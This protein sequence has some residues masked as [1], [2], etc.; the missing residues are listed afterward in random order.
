MELITIQNKIYEINGQKVMLD[1]DLAEMYDVETKVL[2]QAV[3]R[4]LDRFP[5]DFMFRLSVKEWENLRSRFVTSSAINNRSQFV[6]G[7]QKHR[8]KA[9]TPFAF[10]EHGVTMLASTLKS[11]KA[12]AINIQIV[13][14]F[15]L[16]KQ[17]AVSHDDM[18]KKLNKLEKKFNRQFK[19]VYEALNYLL[20]KDKQQIDWQEREMIG[21]KTKEG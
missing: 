8:A 14:A 17:L 13:R 20:Q 1:F 21:F 12:I 4:N 10:T 6:T 15:I 19:D 7:S 18:N 2:N 3:K 11:K 16:L 5:K 9:I